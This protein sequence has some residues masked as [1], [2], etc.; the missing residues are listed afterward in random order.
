MPEAF[1]HDMQGSTLF[2]TMTSDADDE[3]AAHAY[4][5]AIHRLFDIMVCTR[6]TP[7]HALT[8]MHTPAP[9]AALRTRCCSRSRPRWAAAVLHY[10]YVCARMVVVDECVR[11]CSSSR[12]YNISLSN[13]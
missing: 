4:R 12:W 5:P 10:V 6:D 2:G 3:V 8:Y 7:C 1:H 13:H 9:A 11:N